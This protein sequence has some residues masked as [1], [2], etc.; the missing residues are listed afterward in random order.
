MI[1]VKNIKVTHGSKTFSNISTRVWNALCKI[2][3]VNV[4]I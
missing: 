4:T 1:G 2:I 3:E